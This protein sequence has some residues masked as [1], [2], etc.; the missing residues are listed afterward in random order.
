MQ[1]MLL[2]TFVIARSSNAPFLLSVPLIIKRQK[3]MGLPYDVR[4]R[5]FGV[6]FVVI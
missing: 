6:I 2:C 5:L 1:V 4:A 3:C